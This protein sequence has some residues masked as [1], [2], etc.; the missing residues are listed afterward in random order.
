MAFKVRL[1]PELDILG[2]YGAA[3]VKEGRVK[4]PNAADRQGTTALHWMA[5]RGLYG[6][7]CAL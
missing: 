2:E 3:A 1:E 6:D 7:I 4:H 5:H